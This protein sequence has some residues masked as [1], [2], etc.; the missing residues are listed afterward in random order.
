[1]NLAVVAADDWAYVHYADGEYLCFDLDADPTWGSLSPDPDRALAGARSM[2]TWRARHAER[3]FTDM[4]VID[5]GVGRV[6]PLEA[7][8]SEP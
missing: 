2:L 5:G 8:T 4:L 1:M 3:T 6:P 7:M